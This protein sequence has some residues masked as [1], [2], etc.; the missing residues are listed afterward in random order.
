MKLL[1]KSWAAAV[2]GV[3]ALF[4]AAGAWAGGL[5]DLNG[6][7]RTIQDYAGKGKWLVVMIWASDCHFCN[8]EAHNYVDF[9]TFHKDKDATVL[10]ISMDGLG[11]KAAAE[12]FIK[13]HSVN[14][15]NLIGSPETVAGMYIQLTGAPF[16]G[17]P[18][19]LIY[20]PSGKLRAQQVGAVPT[21][22]IEDFIKS[23]TKASAAETRG[24]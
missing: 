16:G 4:A 12:S 8:T 1:N 23:H 3:L 7:A 14:F 6:N 5:T 22:L 15:P 17:T 10:G 20:D 18:A 24:S 9:Q 2:V 11:N 21:D 19:F 13:R